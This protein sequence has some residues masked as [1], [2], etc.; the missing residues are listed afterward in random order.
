MKNNGQLLHIS[1][2]WWRLSRIE[3]NSRILGK[4]ILRLICDD[5]K[6]T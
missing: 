1:K 2:K 6:M 5:K 4:A 3:L